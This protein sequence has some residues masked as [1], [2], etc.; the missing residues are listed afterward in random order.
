MFW[1][2]IFAGV[3]FYLAVAL[4]WGTCVEIRLSNK[5]AFKQDRDLRIATSFFIG[6]TWP[7]T[8]LA[9]LF[10]A[11]LVRVFGRRGQ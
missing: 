9:S 1:V 3:A 4:Y 2:L 11:G 10:Y 5:Y 8:L 7:V 6:M